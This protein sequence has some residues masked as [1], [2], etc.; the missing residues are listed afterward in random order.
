MDIYYDTS[1]Y[2]LTGRNM[3]LRKRDQHLELKVSV[4]GYHGTLDT[5]QEIVDEAEISRF[6]SEILN[7]PLSELLAS[8][9]LIPFCTMQTKRTKY[10][11]DE[12]TIDVDCATVE[13][14]IVAVAE[15]E[16]LVPHEK[17]VSS[18]EIKIL[19]MAKK[20]SLD[21]DTSVQG[22]LPSYLQ[23]K[24]PEHYHYLLEAGVIRAA[25]KTSNS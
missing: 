2:T 5:Y 14:F 10:R 11:L 8:R 4:K 9:R 22:K 18:A 17:E 23:E 16:L 25:T 3:W 1:T 12:F 7:K 20:L 13:D 24:A 19:S 6:L 21:T 15:I